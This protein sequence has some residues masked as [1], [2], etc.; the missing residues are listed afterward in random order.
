MLVSRSNPQIIRY[1]GTP[2]NME[3][4]FNNLRGDDN[5]FIG[6]SFPAK[7]K[8]LFLIEQ[9]CKKNALRDCSVPNF[10]AISPELTR[11]FEPKVL[12]WHG[13]ETHFDR[14]E[15]NR[16]IIRFIEEQ[17]CPLF[18]SAIIVRSASHIEGSISGAAPGIFRSGSP[19]ERNSTLLANDTISVIRSGYEPAAIAYHRLKG[20]PVSPPGLI[21]QEGLTRHTI[22]VAHSVDP[23]NITILLTRTEKGE[24]CHTQFLVSYDE[25]ETSDL[26]T[27]HKAIARAVKALSDNGRIP[28]EIEF[29]YNDTVKILQ[30]RFVSLPVDRRIDT[31]ELKEIAQTRE[32]PVPGSVAFEHVVVVPRIIN[33]STSSTMNHVKEQLFFASEQLKGLPYAVIVPPEIVTHF[34]SG[35]HSFRQFL[36][37]ASVIIEHFEADAHERFGGSSGAHWERML[38]ENG[39][40]FMV[41]DHEELDSLLA[42]LEQN[43]EQVKLEELPIQGLAELMFDGPYHASRDKQDAGE[44]VKI[45]KVPPMVA[46]SRPT[47]SGEIMSF[48]QFEFPSHLS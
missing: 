35:Y 38:A 15:G 18:K 19:R 22:G 13:V 6:D 45:L 30:H 37:G 2:E 34:E 11:R 39:Q 29:G 23:Q 14:Q 47:R 21:F 20:L 44:P 7:V 28:I 41:T 32:C 17:I 8:S 12:N 40:L 31:Q 5:Q 27:Q 48:K 25:I 33:R 10:V 24:D 42:H 1:L 26:T 3:R 46:I 4:M 36:F 16:A 43:G 9:L